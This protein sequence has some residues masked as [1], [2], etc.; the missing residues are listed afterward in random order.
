MFNENNFQLFESNT[1]KEEENTNLLEN[2]LEN[3]KTTQNLK[4][5]KISEKTKEENESKEIKEII[6]YYTKIKIILIF[7]KNKANN[8]NF[9]KYI[10]ILNKKEI[11][12]NILYDMKLLNNNEVISQN[13]ISLFKK[14]HDKN[15]TDNI[16]KKI[17][18]QLFNNLI[19]FINFRLSTAKLDIYKLKKIDYKLYSRTSREINVKNLNMKIKDL[20]SLE[21]S[22]K[23][24]LVKDKNENKKNIQELLKIAK[25]KNYIT[26]ESVF[27]LTFRDWIDL[28]TMKKEGIKID[29]LDSLL[30]KILE[31]IEDEEYFVNFVFCLYNHE[32]WFLFKKI[33]NYKKGKEK[34][35]LFAK[36]KKGKSKKQKNKNREKWIYLLI[37]SLLKKKGNIW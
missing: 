13:N 34:N 36:K 4:I 23:Y 7:E 6:A 25:E 17:N 21:I 26:I 3:K 11:S 14:K 10:D 18:I 32:R 12:A 2:S 20:L 19:K 27:N 29:G 35:D 30:N 16:I 28:F 22:S 37:E 24:S 31:N 5:D 8:N 9:Q 33:G 1:K 15:S